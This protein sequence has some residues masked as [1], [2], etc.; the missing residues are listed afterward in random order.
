MKKFA[1]I[2]ITTLLGACSLQSQKTISGI[3]QGTL[4]C[5]DCE[6]IQAK[7]TLNH[8]KTYQYSTVY[9]K[10]KKQ[11]PFVEKGLYTW[12]D[13]KENVI[14]LSNSGNLALQ[15]NQDYVELCDSQGNVAKN[16][17]N[18]KLYKMK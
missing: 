2:A 1:L 8:D 7:L 13:Q 17:N 6:K 15:V 9:F 10:N 16:Q 11:H 4:P 12:D 18:Y 14:R 3:Y 5:S